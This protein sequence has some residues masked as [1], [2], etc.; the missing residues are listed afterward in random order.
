MVNNKN[1][2]VKTYENYFLADTPACYVA[3]LIASFK[4]HSIAEFTPYLGSRVKDVLSERD[5]L[6]L[7]ED[8]KRHIAIGM[9]NNS[10]TYWSFEWEIF[11]KYQKFLRAYV[12]TS[13]GWKSTLWIYP[14]RT[15]SIYQACELFVTYAP[16]AAYCFRTIYITLYY[17]KK[18]QTA[19]DNFFAKDHISPLRIQYPY[20]KNTMAPIYSKFCIS[21]RLDGW[22]DIQIPVNAK[23]K[24]MEARFIKECHKNGGRL[25]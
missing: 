13:S 24:E 22:V 9:V 3:E 11:D 7:G 4:E 21:D 1:S 10:P 18:I 25:P 8:P 2:T 5:R 19:W 6:S 17:F 20:T 16:G 14:Y 12:D 23:A 15:D